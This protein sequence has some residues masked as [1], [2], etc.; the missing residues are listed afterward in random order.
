MRYHF[1]PVSMADIKKTTSN[2]CWQGC[3]ETGSPH[4]LLVGMKTDTATRENHIEGPLKTKNK[5]TIWSGNLT[6][7][8]IYRRDKNSKR[9][10][11]PSVHGSI[12]NSQDMDDTVTHTP[13][14]IHRHT[15]TH[16]KWNITQL[17]KIMEV[18]IWSNMNGPRGYHTKWSQTEEDKYRMVSLRCGI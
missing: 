18:A 9:Y 11:H 8:H 17:K 1:K 14:H 5:V 16:I 15:R 10:M 12:Y 3:R 4:A 7:K 13:I 6:P 2:K